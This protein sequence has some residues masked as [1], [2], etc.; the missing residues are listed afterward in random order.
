M[1]LKLHT[2]SKKGQW[3]EMAKQLTDD[4]VRLFV[5]VGRHDEIMEAI[6]MRYE[7]VSDTIYVNQVPGVDPK[8]PAD[9]IQEMKTMPVAFKEFRNR[10]EE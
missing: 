10:F 9:L 7:G 2:M 1:G 5:A 6:K 4:H 3:K 8:V